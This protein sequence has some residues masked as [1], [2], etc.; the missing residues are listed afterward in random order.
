MKGFTLIEVIIALIVV[1]VGFGVFISVQAYLA[2]QTLDYKEEIESSEVANSIVTLFENIEPGFK[3]FNG[4]FGELLIRFKIPDKTIV[5]SNL[6]KILVNISKDKR[7]MMFSDQVVDLD[8]ILIE[9]TTGSGREF[10]YEFIQ[11]PTG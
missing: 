2:R 5:R 1:A 3:Q 9:I 8:V 4:T 10:F 7:Q 11:R 6:S